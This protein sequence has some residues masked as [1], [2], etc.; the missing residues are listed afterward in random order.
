MR[1]TEKIYGELYKGPFSFRKFFNEHAVGILGTLAFHMIILIVFLLVKMQ[2]FKNPE[3]LDLLLEFA[4]IPEQ[5]TEELTNEQLTE[6]EYYQ[7]L[8]EQQLSASNR[9]SNSAE[10]L[11]EEISTENYVDEVM[12][13]LDET[14]SEEW[15]KEQEEIRKKLNQEDLVPIKKEEEDQKEEDKSYSGPTNI[16]YQ[17]LEEP[18]DRKSKY[19][20]IPVYKCRGFG[21][22]EVKVSVDQQGNVSSAKAN[23]V[24]ATEDPDCLAEVAE[25]YA[26]MSSFRGNN[27]APTNQIAVITYR[28]IAQ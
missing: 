4:D 25:R 3:E 5:V 28:F 16:S 20:P 17:F 12:K 6:E 18:K 8:L 7:R 19:M 2:S 23:V 9:A 14:R 27:A 15:L 26:R 10:K 24:E 21:L 11:E 22:V 1:E 13:E